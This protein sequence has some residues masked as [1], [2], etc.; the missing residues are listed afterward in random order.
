MVTWFSLQVVTVLVEGFYKHIV[1][2][3]ACIIG[4]EL[5]RQAGYFT[6]TN[7]FLFVHSKIQPNNRVKYA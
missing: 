2:F 7:G 3:L 1:L 5:G 4:I 6:K